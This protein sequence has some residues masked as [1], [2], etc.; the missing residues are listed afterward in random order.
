M[1]RGLIFNENIYNLVKFVRSLLL[2]LFCLGANFAFAQIQGEQ[3]LIPSYPYYHEKQSLYSYPDENV[4]QYAYESPSKWTLITY[5]NYSFFYKSDS[6]AAIQKYRYDIILR[7]YRPAS[8]VK[9]ST[10]QEYL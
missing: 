2:I 5:P 8:K 10:I 1:F 6:L 9:R 4:K 7:K 3:P